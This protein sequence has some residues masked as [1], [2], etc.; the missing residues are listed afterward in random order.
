MGMQASDTGSGAGPWFRGLGVFALYGGS[1]ALALAFVFAGWTNGSIGQAASV[2][3][4]A[5][6]NIVTAPMEIVSGLVRLLI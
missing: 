6:T 3:T 1:A 5:A 4:G 2:L